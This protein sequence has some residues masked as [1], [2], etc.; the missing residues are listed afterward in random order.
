[1]RSAL[2]VIRNSGKTGDLAR[3]AE[4]MEKAYKYTNEASFQTQRKDLIPQVPKT[5]DA[6]IYN[7]K[8]QLTITSDQGYDVYYTFDVPACQ[9]C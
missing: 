3:A 9:K 7:D 1:M 2:R 6:G 8:I 4:L 5:K